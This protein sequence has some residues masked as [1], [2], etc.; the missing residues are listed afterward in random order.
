ME[1][2]VGRNVPI[3][4]QFDVRL[5][6]PLDV[7]GQRAEI[8]RPVDLG[9]ERIGDRRVVRRLRDAAERQPVALR[10]TI[11]LQRQR[12]ALA[13]PRDAGEKA[14]E[15]APRPVPIA[16][17]QE[18]AEATESDVPLADQTGIRLQRV[19]PRVISADADLGLGIGIGLIGTGD[20]VDRASDGRRPVKRR[21][22][23]ALYLYVFRRPL[24]IEEVDPKHVEVFRIVLR[25]PVDGDRYAPLIES[26]HPHR[27][28]ADSVAV[29]GV[30][31]DGRPRGQDYGQVLHGRLS[32]ELARRH[33]R[34]RDRIHRP[35][36][37]RRRHDDLFLRH[38]TRLESELEIDG[39]TAPHFDAAAFFGESDVR[40]DDVVASFSH[41]R[42]VKSTG[43]IRSRPIAR[44]LA[45]REHDRRTRERPSGLVD[46]ASDHRSALRH[47]RQSAG[48][49]EESDP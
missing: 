8:E 42:E 23:A 47:G 20:D 21:T 14:V 39:A 25:D 2:R 11:G 15:L 26:P 22:G 10:S 49:A 46:Y 34:E 48:G 36:R 43:A 7:P 4:Q 16:V 5:M 32:F 35:T 13:V 17:G 6:E 1:L 40:G 45:V 33:V 44:P 18:P 19:S 24:Q 30:V 3:V 12:R 9:S 38:R 37:P 28:I 41:G 29:F 27:R 31:R